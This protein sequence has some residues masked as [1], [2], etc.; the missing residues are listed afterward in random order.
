MVPTYEGGYSTTG[1]VP[2]M[3][4]ISPPNTDTVAEVAT[5]PPEDG[6]NCVCRKDLGSNGEDRARRGACHQSPQFRTPRFLATICRARG[7]GDAA[8]RTKRVPEENPSTM[9]AR[10]CPTTRPTLCQVVMRLSPT[11]S[12]YFPSVNRSPPYTLSDAGARAIKTSCL[13]KLVT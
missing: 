12:F 9:R 1:I 2:Q 4:S 8:T 6:S 11:T 10:E 13:R 3:Q 7:H 5:E